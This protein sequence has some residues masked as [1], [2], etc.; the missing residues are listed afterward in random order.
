V[1][2][3][4]QT[5]SIEVAKEGGVA[6]RLNDTPELDLGAMLTIECQPSRIW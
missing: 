6:L 4:H 5:Q 3:R 2:E 1:D